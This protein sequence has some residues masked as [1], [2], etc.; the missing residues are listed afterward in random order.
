MNGRRRDARFLPSNPWNA[1]LHTKEDV[2]LERAD[3]QALWALSDT[4]ARR[5]DSLTLEIATGGLR[6]DVRVL[7]SEPVVSDGGVLHRVHL[8]VLDPDSDADYYPY[9]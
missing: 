8:Q 1:A 9:R 6:V 7:N 4:P 3:G 5:G 2:V